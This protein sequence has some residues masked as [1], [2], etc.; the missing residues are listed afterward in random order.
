MN[1]NTPSNNFPL[2]PAGS[3]MAVCVDVYDRDEK[4]T[5]YQTKKDNGDLD[6]REHIK[7]AYIEFFTDKGM[8]VRFKANATLGSEEKESNLRK[9]VK[10]WFSEITPAELAKFN[11]ECMV[12]RGGWIKVAHRDSKGKTYANVTVAMEPPPGS[13]VPTIPVSFVRQ[14]EKANAQ[15]VATTPPAITNDPTAIYDVTAP[16]RIGGDSAFPDE[17]APF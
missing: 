5:F 10:G 12:G 9:F 16:A 15:P 4:N 13:P 2:H 8:T 14:K 3:C 17:D 6:M 7:V 11:P 1:W